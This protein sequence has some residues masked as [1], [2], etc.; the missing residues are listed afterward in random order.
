MTA[1]R[2]RPPHPGQ[3]RFENAQTGQAE[4]R[5]FSDVPDRIAFTLIEGAF[6][7]VVRVVEVADPQ[8]VTQKLFSADGILRT[9][10]W[11]PHP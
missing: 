11:A 5:D 9:T 1:K 6:H 2:P 4:D 10:T 8:G 7:P 3:I